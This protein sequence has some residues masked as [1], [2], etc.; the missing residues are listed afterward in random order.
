MQPAMVWVGLDRVTVLANLSGDAECLE[1]CV[2]FASLDEATHAVF[3]H[4]HLFVTLNPAGPHLKKTPVHRP[5][6]FP[7]SLGA[8]SCRPFAA[9]WNGS[10]S[11]GRMIIRC[12]TIRF[13]VK[14]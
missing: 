7:H 6:E 9:I 4:H 1:L 13:G 2:S 12:R 11:C 14:S 10:Q 8:Q 5:N 3:N